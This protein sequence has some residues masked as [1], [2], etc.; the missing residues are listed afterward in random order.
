MPS[1]GEETID[2]PKVDDYLIRIKLSQL[3][4]EREFFGGALVGQS[5]Y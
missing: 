1:V 4:F 5:Q 2:I 3:E